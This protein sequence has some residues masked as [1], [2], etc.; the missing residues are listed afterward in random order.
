MEEQVDRQD[1]CLQ[2]EEVEVQVL[3]ERQEVDLQQEQEEMV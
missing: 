3:P 1:L 2:V